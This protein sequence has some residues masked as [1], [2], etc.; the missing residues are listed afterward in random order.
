MD[1]SQLNCFDWRSSSEQLA[2][3]VPVEC[4][5]YRKL[6]LEDFSLEAVTHSDPE[7]S[8]GSGNL[9]CGVASHH[10]GQGQIDEVELTG[11]SQLGPSTYGLFDI[12]CSPRR[13]SLSCPGCGS[14]QRVARGH[15]H[16]RCLGLPGASPA[17]TLQSFFGMD[18]QQC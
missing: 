3:Q 16:L 18:I 4:V 6:I 14:N 7:C 9:T 2:D 17:T 15:W 10:G 13:A 1:D 11:G 8:H 5:D 12:H